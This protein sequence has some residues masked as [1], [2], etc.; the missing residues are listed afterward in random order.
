MV[1]QHVVKAHDLSRGNISVVATMCNVL[2][3][4]SSAERDV[5]LP[6]LDGQGG[7]EYS[8]IKLM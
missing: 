7:F 1:E 8:D 5:L 2:Q 6:Q 4:E 3:N